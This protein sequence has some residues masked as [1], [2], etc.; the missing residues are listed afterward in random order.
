MPGI[1]NRN[2]PEWYARKKTPQLPG[3]RLERM[4]NEYGIEAMIGPAGLVCFTQCNV[5]Y[6]SANNVFPWRRAIMSLIYNAASNACTGAKRPW[7]QNNR[8]VTPLQPLN[9]DSLKALA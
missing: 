4:A 1:L 9:G 7:C 5:L 6:G 3:W 2:G 8:D